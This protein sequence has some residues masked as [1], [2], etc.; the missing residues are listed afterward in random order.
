MDWIPWVIRAILIIVGIIVAIMVW[1]GKKEG[2]Y[3][4]YSFRFF[5]IGTTASIIGIFLLVLPFMTD[6]KFYGLLLTV[7]GALALI[8]G[9]VIRKIWEKNR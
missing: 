8:I 7:V 9:L 5:V 4:R 3:Q 1:K 2:R 6:L